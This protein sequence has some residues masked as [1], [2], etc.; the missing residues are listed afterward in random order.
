MCIESDY[1]AYWVI[2]EM[3]VEMCFKEESL[4]INKIQNSI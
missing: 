2:E 1:Q 4:I 3:D